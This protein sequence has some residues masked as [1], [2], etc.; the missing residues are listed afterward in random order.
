MLLS[1]K[2]CSVI[3]QMLPQRFTTWVFKICANSSIKPFKNW[4]ISR[5]I[6]KYGVNI[7]EAIFQNP[8]DFKTF[9][10]FFIRQL[11][12]ELRPICHEKQAIVS[13]VDG[14]VRQIGAIEHGK[15]FNAKGHY[16]ALYE[17]LGGSFE[18]CVPFLHGKYAN[19]Y[20]A[21]CDYHRVHMPYAGTLKTMIYVPGK[22][23]PVK[24][25]SVKANP[26]LFSQNE[27]LV[28]MFDTNIGPMAVVLV[29]AMIVG[30]M[31]VVWHGDILREKK[32]R[33]WDYSNQL[34]RLNAGDELGH[35]KLGS[36]VICLFAN[37]SHSVTWIK[38]LERLHYGQ[39]I[40]DVE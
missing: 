22:L 20:L 37:H 23:F 36:T 15:I 14:C 11:K 25:S 38:E 1:K 28:L 26:S 18:R 7:H 21:P 39:K 19:L 30:N 10:E 13:P 12:Q 24:E 34:I 27:R 6:V 2:C 29:G 31:H 40:A 17:L 5:F 3:E 9:N 16:F 4:L 33:L 8:E 32:I 35:F